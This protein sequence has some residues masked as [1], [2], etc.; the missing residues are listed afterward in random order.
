MLRIAV[1]PGG[2]GPRWTEW[3][4]TMMKAWQARTWSWDFDGLSLHNY[5]VVK[6]PP[7]YTSVGFGETEYAEILKKTLEM[8]SII[9]EHSTI[10]DKYDP[11]KKIALVV[12][13]W[14]AG[15]PHCPAATPAS[16]CSRTACATPSSR[17]ST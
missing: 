15:T 16:W 11:E 5:T 17:R 13:E 2:S 10:M 14:C 8:D 6:W 12:D 1:G 7:A 9:K 3:T 4:D